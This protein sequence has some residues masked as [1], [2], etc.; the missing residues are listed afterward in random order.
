MLAFSA[1]IIILSCAFSLGESVPAGV[2]V[3]GVDVGGK[4]YVVAAEEI[5]S[6]TEEEVRQKR[7]KIVSGENEY[8]FSYPEISYK[9]NVYSLLKNA[10]KGQA[11]TAETQY[12]LCGADEIATGICFSET[13]LK[14]EPYAKFSKFG[15]PFTFLEGNDGKIADKVK[16]LNDISTSLNGDGAPVKVKFNV[17]KRQKSV[18]EVKREHVLLSKFTTYFDGSNLNRV[19]NIRLSAARLNG[20]VIEGGKTLS[21][22]DTVGERVTKRGFLPAKIILGGEFVD[23]VGGGVCQVSTTLYNSALLAGM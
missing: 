20:A 4:S 9:D 2:S 3:N 22:N 18:E 13:H 16:L 14:V 7:L 5:R 19:S 10:K 11:L 15:E 6:Q 21:F 8:V 1:G 23:G 12:Y 17:Q